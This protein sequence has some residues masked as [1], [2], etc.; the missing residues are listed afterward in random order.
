MKISAIVESIRGWLPADSPKEFILQIFG[1][2]LPD[3]WKSEIDSDLDLPSDVE[4]PTDDDWKSSLHVQE[5][6][7]WRY[8]CEI[9]R[10]KCSEEE[11]KNRLAWMSI[12]IVI[13]YG[14]KLLDHTSA[15]VAVTMPYRLASKRNRFNG[16][17]NK[18]IAPER[19]NELI[20]TV[21]KYLKESSGVAGPYQ[22]STNDRKQI[23]TVLKR[24]ESFEAERSGRSN[25]G[26]RESKSRTTRKFV[27][28]VTN[29]E[30]STF[31]TRS[32]GDD[33]EITELVDE[34]DVSRDA[35]GIDK[36][37]YQNDQPETDVTVI[38][39]TDRVSA[40][41][42]RQRQKIEVN[43]KARAIRRRDMGFPTDSR[44]L[45][46]QMMQ[47]ICHQLITQLDDEIPENRVLAALVLTSIFTSTQP[48]EWLLMVVR[49][50]QPEEL[51]LREDHHHYWLKRNLEIGRNE[52]WDEIGADLFFNDS[53]SME[54][55]L[56]KKWVR[57]LSDVGAPYLGTKDVDD[58][59]KY[60]GEK[61]GIVGLTQHRISL[62][63]NNVLKRHL[64]ADAY[65]D[66]ITGTP[67]KH[68]PVLFYISATQDRLIS[69]TIDA[70]ILL[71]GTT[72]TT[73]QT[74]N[75]ENHKRIGSLRTP[76]TAIV[77][78][79]MNELSNVIKNNLDRHSR[80]YYLTIW[81]WH[82]ALLMT[83]CRPVAGAPGTL[84]NID[85]SLRLMTVSDKENRLSSSSERII[86][87]SDQF[88]RSIEFYVEECQFIYQNSRMT[89]VFSKDA[90]YLVDEKKPLLHLFVDNV[91]TPANRKLIN[92]VMEK[93][94]PF[95]A[96]WHRH[97]FRAIM[98]DLGADDHLLRAIMGHEPPDQEF[99]HPYSGVTLGDYEDARM[100]IEEMSVEI[101]QLEMPY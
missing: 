99:L 51:S 57:N 47:A 56:P 55:P 101:L 36:I 73:G 61:L 39:D 87:I 84:S 38:H 30:N 17:Y 88:I 9:H 3:E 65:A 58:Y 43:G 33:S 96:N 8:V 93:S 21:A 60:L 6:P 24:Y 22:L 11:M 70:E 72:H 71:T 26:T 10:N 83:G 53:R 62:G 12:N 42:S 46:L 31:Y 2:N 94:W 54:I 4:R 45:N 75:T 85:K 48:K 5:W 44:L 35:H 79:L 68:N 82:Y 50:E 34:V 15:E 59:I 76:N 81:T 49:G 95:D 40:R 66:V 19:P 91:W 27:S 63:Y 32:L 67:A 64:K 29:S 18:L 20:P 16:L 86:P 89:Q 98:S 80:F 69:L 74:I 7:I 28:D 23:N 77:S 78:T 13:I 14:L 90:E 52:K 25:T 37:E 97:Y 41:T 1:E 100:L 92:G